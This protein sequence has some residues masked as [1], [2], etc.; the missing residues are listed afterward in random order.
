MQI[1]GHHLCLAGLLALFAC[2]ASAEDRGIVRVEPHGRAAQ[3][4]LQLDTRA[5][6]SQ[7]FDLT[8]WKLTL[9]SGDEIKTDRLIAGY[10][11]PSAFY[12]DPESGG[13]VF[14]C[15]NRAGTTR[16][17]NYSRSELREMLAP[18]ES[19]DDDE[20]NWT[21]EDGG[22][23][24]A[25]LRVD[26]VS[27][28]GDKKKVGRVVIGQIH[29][30]DS[31]VI[32]LYYQN[33]PDQPKGRIYAGLDDVSG[34]TVWSPNIVPNANGGGIALGEEFDYRIRLAGR[35]LTVIVEPAS[36]GRY[37]YT[38]TIDDGYLGENLY[39]KAGVYN[40]NNTGDGGDFV[41]ATFFR[42]VRSHP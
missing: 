22:T 24:D 19:A 26:R 7:N 25:R 37:V 2:S 42:L 30:P 20:N 14:R 18:S 12:T 3:V 27:R 23:L 6:P 8:H 34:D 28:T 41:Q 1:S 36:G 4:Q 40:Q 33:K 32:R 13:L 17:S 16:H 10:T 11:N 38:R 21:P 35:Q 39:F 9:P 5:K 15:P 29:G 31:E